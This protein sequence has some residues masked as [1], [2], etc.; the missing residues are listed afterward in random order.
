MGARFEGDNVFA[1]G[2]VT[3]KKWTTTSEVT[4]Y[5]PDELFEFCAAELT[6][7]RFECIGIDQS[8]RVT[9]T[10]VHPPY[11][12]MQKLVYER[13]A[14]RP[15]SMVTGMNETLARMKTVIEQGS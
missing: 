14:K 3:L 9:E 13:L 10:F 7:W 12:G 4:Q 11:E 8:T 15:K 1:L 6:T 5:R 2:P